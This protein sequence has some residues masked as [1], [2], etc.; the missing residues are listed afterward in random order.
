ME[1]L[2]YDDNLLRR[3]YAE[4]VNENNDGWVKEHYK[5]MYELRLSQLK[6]K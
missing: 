3:Y 2:Q 4:M 5:K 6:L 1:H